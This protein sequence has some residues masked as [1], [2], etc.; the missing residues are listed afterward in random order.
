MA[1]AH[2]SSRL[3]EQVPG[4]IASIY[5]ASLDSQRWSGFL[6][7]LGVALQSPAQVIWA[8]DFAQRTVDLD[9]GFGS[10]ASSR[11]FAEAE[12][13]SFAEYYC[14][15]NVWL[16]DPGLHKA[17]TVVNSSALFADHQL[18]STEW[19]GGWLQPQ[20]L[21]YSC[22]AV[23]DHQHERSFNVTLLRSQ[24]AGAYSAQELGLVQQLMPHL[25]T[26]FAIHRRLYK[27]QALLNASLAALEG[28]SMGVILLDEQA[29]VLY[30]NQRA[31]SLMQSS[32]LLCESSG[33][34][35]RAPNPDDDRWL[36]KALRECVATGAGLAQHEGRAS[37][38]KGLTGQQLQVLAAPLPMRSSP[39]GESCAAMLLISDPQQETPNL[40]EVFRGLYRLTL[41]E[42]LLAQAMVNGWSLQEFADRQGLSI[43]TARTQ[44]KS[45]ALKVGVNRQADFVRVLLTGP[46]M[47]L[48][49]EQ[50][51]Q[52]SHLSRA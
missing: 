21:F 48:W 4:L 35:V 45:A 14:Q 38:F 10:F 31:Q 33:N 20:D 24:R 16:Q 50:A 51:A 3:Q 42:S 34:R 7:Q 5:E 9:G 25:Q 44:F 40:N 27:T 37:R 15:R 6:E 49:R 1:D 22:A 30:S 46:A 17:G 11:G 43:H 12:L 19:Y 41:A 32:Q 36:Q 18:P 8:N 29:C 52:H 13:Q 26:A 47:L 23:V 28:L 39:Y 2:L